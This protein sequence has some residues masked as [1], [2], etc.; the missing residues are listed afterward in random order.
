MDTPRIIR[1]RYQLERP[2]QLG[3]LATTY[4]LILGIAGSLLA[5]TADK[6]TARILGRNSAPTPSRAAD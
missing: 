3:P 6:F 5:R 2:L 4:V 1:E